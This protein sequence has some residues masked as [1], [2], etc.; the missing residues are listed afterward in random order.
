MRNIILTIC[1]IYS[2]TLAVADHHAKKLHP[3]YRG[4]KLGLSKNEILKTVKP[5]SLKLKKTTQHYDVT[6]NK[7]VSNPNIWWIGE[8]GQKEWIQLN[9]KEDKVV[10]L[11]VF[12]TK[13]TRNEI[14]KFINIYSKF[15]IMN[16]KKE[17][18]KNGFVMGSFDAETKDYQC[19][20]SWGT[21]DP[22][23]KKTFRFDIQI[24]DL[25]LYK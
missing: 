13:K 6:L 7:M 25:N 15:P 3:V 20:V 9:F 24:S 17:H 4:L 23:Y 10:I 14:D 16:P 21:D 5:W 18:A 1:M 2:S 11:A 19:S 12:L 22:I 8:P